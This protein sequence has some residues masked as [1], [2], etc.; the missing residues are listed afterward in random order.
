MFLDTWQSC[1]VSIMTICCGLFSVSSAMREEHSHTLYLL[2]CLIIKSCGEDNYVS[3]Q[4][5]ILDLSNFSS[6]FHRIITCVGCSI[7]WHEMPIPFFLSLTHLKRMS[8]FILLSALILYNVW[9]LLF[10]KN[11]WPYCFLNTNFPLHPTSKLCSD[12]TNSMRVFCVVV[13]CC[14]NSLH[15][16]SM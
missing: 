11:I 14:A 7:G 12:F 6:S 5:T 10:C 4:P 13:L 3:R 16:H 15:N 1:C 9:N 2:L 8:A